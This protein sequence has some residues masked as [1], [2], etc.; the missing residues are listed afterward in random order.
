MVSKRVVSL[1]SLAAYCSAAVLPLHP[2]ADVDIEPYE[3]G[4]A[5]WFIAGFLPDE[6]KLQ[7]LD[8]DGELLQIEVGQPDYEQKAEKYLSSYLSSLEANNNP[9]SASE[10]ASGIISLLKSSNNR[11]SVLDVP[12]S[13]LI[14]ALQNSEIAGES[15]DI[16]KEL[17]KYIVSARDL[18][19]ELFPQTF[20]LETGAAGT[21]TG[22]EHISAS[23]SF[24]DN[25]LSAAN[26]NE[27]E[28]EQG[29]L[30]SEDKDEDTDEPAE[31]NSKSSGPSASSRFTLSLLSASIAI[32]AMVSL[33]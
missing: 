14:S 27:T 9:V 30:S 33:F 21:K 12:Y 16:A 23:A 2:R 29:D 28:S 19:P 17:I 5:I 22:S 10:W 15:A 7:E 13:S 8:N 24:S 6:S 18:A 32:S 31:S 11:A 25:K 4:H 26:S 3:I 20:E 1:L